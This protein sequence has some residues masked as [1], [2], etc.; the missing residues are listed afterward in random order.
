V[1][2]LQLANCYLLLA[3]YNL[4][5]LVYLICSARMINKPFGMFSPTANS[6]PPA[7]FLSMP[8]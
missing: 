2:Y 3:S 4:Q 1:K 8:A 6:K 7:A 5:E